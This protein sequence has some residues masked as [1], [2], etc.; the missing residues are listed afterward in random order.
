MSNACSRRDLLLLGALP[1]MA[2]RREQHEYFGETTMPSTR[3]LVFENGGEPESLDPARC[4]LDVETPPLSA[5]F[6]GLTGRHPVTGEPIAALATHYEVNDT[7]TQLTFYLRGHRKPDGVRLPNTSD[8]PA[9]YRRGRAAPSDGIPALWSDGSGITAEDFAYSWRRIVDPATAAYLAPVYFSGIRAVRALDEFTFQVD[10]AQ[11]NPIFIGFLWLPAFAAVPRHTVEAAKRTGREASWTEPQRM[12]SSGPFV[13]HEWLPRNRIVLRKNP[14]YYEAGLIDIDDLVFL[15]TVHGATRINLYRSGETH[16]TDV[17]AIP[18]LFVPAV[19]GARDARRSSACRVVWYSINTTRPPMDNVL[20]RYA[21]NMAID[22]SSI[23]N[24][25]GAGRIPARGFV[26]PIPGYD[27]P[28]SLPV[29][30]DGATY[31]VLSFNSAAAQKLLAQAGY[32]G[33][34]GKDGRQMKVTF[35]FPEDAGT[36]LLHEIVQQQ[37]RSVLNIEGTLNVQESS[38]FW[39]Q[40]CL[41]RSYEGVVRDSWT[42]VVDDPYDFLLEFGAAQFS[43]ASWID[44]TFDAMV[45]EATSVLNPAERM[46][47]LAEV[48]RYLL[49]QMPLLPVYYD[50][51]LSLQKPYVRGFPQNRLGLPIF[52]YAWIDNNWR[53]S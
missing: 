26:P 10:L 15:P 8:L 24:T 48:E 29:M 9:E 25:F 38:V 13:L 49:R 41:M 6:E 23:A 33:G 17:R 32:A 37:W 34:I 14:R 44:K 18:P 42:A 3:R 43:C 28:R 47:K 19:A 53:S 21:L 46:R 12:V 2:C 4:I 50:S 40:T 45:A 11:P 35:T 22:R 1:F 31:D 39:S 16:V 36:R 52:K 30:V 20:V 7:C 5:L 27:A 51:W